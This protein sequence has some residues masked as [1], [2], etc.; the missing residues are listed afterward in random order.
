VYSAL[1]A[2]IEGN[3]ATSDQTAAAVTKCVQKAGVR[4]KHISL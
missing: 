3:C 4:N 1:G 2:G